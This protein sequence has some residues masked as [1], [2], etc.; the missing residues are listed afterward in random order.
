MWWC[1]VWLRLLDLGLSQLCCW[2][3]DVLASDIVSVGWWFPGKLSGS[4]HGMMLK[5]WVCILKLMVIWKFEVVWMQCIKPKACPPRINC[6]LWN[7]RMG[8]H[9]WNIWI[10]SNTAAGTSLL[11][12][13]WNLFWDLIQMKVDG[14]DLPIWTVMKTL[15]DLIIW[16]SVHKPRELICILL[17]G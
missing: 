12:M 9:S 3:S 17:F 4:Q 15:W 6:I 11:E 14:I 2:K 1:F 8:W 10:L 7:I 16:L 5:A 13:M